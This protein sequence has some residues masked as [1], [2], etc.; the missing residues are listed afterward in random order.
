MKIKYVRWVIIGKYG[1]YTGQYLLRKD[2]IRLH[3]KDLGKTWDYCKKK[4]D[5]AIKATITYTIK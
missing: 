2:A 1:L 4:G 5:R 3:C